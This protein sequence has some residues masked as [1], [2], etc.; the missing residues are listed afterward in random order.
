LQTSCPLA[1]SHIGIVILVGTMIGAYFP[2]KS[3]RGSE[4]MLSL[5][6]E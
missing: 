4:K 1:A 2:E 6:I 5:R 3:N